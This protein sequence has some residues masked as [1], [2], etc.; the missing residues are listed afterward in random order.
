[1]REEPLGLKKN[2]SSIPED[3]SG[4]ANFDK[5]RT[6]ITATEEMTGYTYSAKLS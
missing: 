2:I 6:S 3:T 4:N 5:P 1:M